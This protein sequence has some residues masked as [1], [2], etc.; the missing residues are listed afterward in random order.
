MFVIFKLYVVKVCF[1]LF[2]K[3]KL[4]VVACNVHTQKKLGV[5]AIT[6]VPTKHGRGHMIFEG[7]EDT[8][9]L[10]RRGGAAERQRD[11]SV[12][13]DAGDFLSNMSAAEA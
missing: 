1:T 7:G 11:L 10:S 13:A 3:K 2:K 12:H 4:G 9:P 8:L 5:V 6:V